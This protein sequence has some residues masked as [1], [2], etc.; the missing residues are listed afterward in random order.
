MCCTTTVLDRKLVCRSRKSPNGGTVEIKKLTPQKWKREEE[1]S[2]LEP[3]TSAFKPHV[4]A[5]TPP[6]CPGSQS[7]VS[8]ALQRHYQSDEIYR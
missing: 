7:V 1:E 4:N 8:S 2:G 5:T 3:S 6:S